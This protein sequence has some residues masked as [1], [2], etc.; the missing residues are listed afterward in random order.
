ML[1]MTRSHFNQVGKLTQLFKYLNTYS[2]L[3]YNKYRK[4]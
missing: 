4:H 2:Y 1:K 3:N